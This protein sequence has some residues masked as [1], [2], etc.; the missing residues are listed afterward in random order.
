MKVDLKIGD[1]FTRE[2]PDKTL[3]MSIEKIE[4][5]GDRALVHHKVWNKDKPSQDKIATCDWWSVL[6]D[7]IG[8]YWHRVEV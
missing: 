8:L 3:V 4:L 7:I 5:T 6:S 2:L 1:T